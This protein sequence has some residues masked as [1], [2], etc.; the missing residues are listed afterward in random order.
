VR[1]WVS[2]ID[3]D[4]AVGLARGIGTTVPGCTI[5][6]TLLAY[7]MVMVWL[8]VVMFTLC[9]VRW[10]AVIRGKTASND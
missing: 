6:T 8:I 7:W 9:F 2:R 5:P 1:A 4:D 3:R 10:R